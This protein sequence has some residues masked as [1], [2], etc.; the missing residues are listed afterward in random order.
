MLI[1]AALIAILP[2]D[3]VGPGPGTDPQGNPGA[4]RP[5]IVL[6][7][8]DDQG[9]GDTSFNGHPTLKTPALDQMESQS[10]SSTTTSARTS[11]PG[12]WGHPARNHT[13]R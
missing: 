12:T 10:M 4:R 13:P 3:V 2:Q 7:M 11:T 6:V 1:L 9:W 5:N 8:A